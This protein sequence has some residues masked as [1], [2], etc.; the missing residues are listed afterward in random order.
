MKLTKPTLLLYYP[1]LIQLFYLSRKKQ[2]P[3]RIF[4]PA[5]TNN[6]LNW[7]LLLLFL[8]EQLVD[9]RLDSRNVVDTVRRE[10]DDY[11]EHNNC[12]PS[13]CTYRNRS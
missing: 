4:S 7:S 10:S 13:W 3:E 9:E 1:K 12:E 8:S 5:L 6:F 2:K 11:A